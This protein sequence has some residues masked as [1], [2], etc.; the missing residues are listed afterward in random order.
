MNQLV[1]R[2]V[3]I[4]LLSTLV[5]GEGVPVL[6]QDRSQERGKNR[7]FKKR[8]TENKVKGKEKGSLMYQGAHTHKSLAP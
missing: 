1:V 2:A 5:T 4:H 3:E 8:F 6:P 7:F